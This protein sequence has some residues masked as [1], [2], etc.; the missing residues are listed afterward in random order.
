MS[1]AC[2][3]CRSAGH[4]DPCATPPRLPKGRP[5]SHSAPWTGARAGRFP[6]AP[7]VSPPA[8]PGRG[9]P[10]AGRP[11]LAVSLS[12]HL[13]AVRKPGAGLLRQR[14]RPPP[15]PGR[16]ARPGG[17]GSPGRGRL[18]RRAPAACPGGAPLQSCCRAAR[19]QPYRRPGAGARPRRQD[20]GRRARGPGA[21]RRTCSRCGRRPSGRRRRGAPPA[22][23]WGSIHRGCP[24]AAPVQRAARTAR[25]H[26]RPASRRRRRMSTGGAAMTSSLRL[27]GRGCRCTAQLRR[28]L[29]LPP[30]RSGLPLWTRSPEY[31]RRRRRGHGG[32]PAARRRNYCHLW[33]V[34]A[35]SPFRSHRHHC[36]FSGP[37]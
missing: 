9:R 36:S 15:A 31:P 24:S 34:P 29:P 22:G 14:Q 25:R 21:R 23:P 28:R 8:P 1:S 33:P 19:S 12:R 35:R 17:P 30:G 32:G 16:A 2:R 4:R 6:D 7:A 27:D 18:G 11:P 13:R 3:H 20:R 10:A 26:A 37:T 5:E